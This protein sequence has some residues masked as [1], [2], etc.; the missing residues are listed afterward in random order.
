MSACASG[1]LCYPPHGNL[2]ACIAD[3]LFVCSMI[4][5]QRPAYTRASS[6]SFS[7]LCLLTLLS[8]ILV[9]HYLINIVFLFRDYM[10]Y[11]KFD[12]FFAH[13]LESLMVVPPTNMK[14][15]RP[16]SNPEKAEIPVPLDLATYVTDQLPA[17]ILPEDPP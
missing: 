11:Q 6:S 16:V 10:L 3:S 1:S 2:P 17:E 5:F 9:N 15:D 7:H 8:S 4:V 12:F 14:A 13:E